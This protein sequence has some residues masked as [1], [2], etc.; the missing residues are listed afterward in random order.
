MY[1]YT[2]LIKSLVFS[3]TSS[4]D[5]IHR[6]IGGRCST[7]N[8]KVVFK[9]CCRPEDQQNNQSEYI[10]AYLRHCV[11]QGWATG[12]PRTVFIWPALPIKIEYTYVGEKKTTR[13]HVEIT[14][15]YYF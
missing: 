8:M 4:K 10:C 1:G 6:R 15:I 14:C 9:V 13:Q 11:Y 7:N 3:A 5:D 2:V 12:G